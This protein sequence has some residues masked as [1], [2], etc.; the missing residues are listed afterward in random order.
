MVGNSLGWTTT[1]LVVIG[2]PMPLDLV[3][4]SGIEGRQDVLKRSFRCRSFRC[5]PQRIV[6]IF[7]MHIHAVVDATVVAVSAVHGGVGV[8]DWETSR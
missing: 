5:R 8:R 4:S 6:V 7:G 3:S 2:K 1:L